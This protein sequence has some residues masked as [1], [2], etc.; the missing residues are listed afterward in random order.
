[1]FLEQKIQNLSEEYENNNLLQSAGSNT[2]L[3]ATLKLVES[4]VDTP[5]ACGG[6][7]H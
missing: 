1:M 7:I 3:L 6:A 2:P 5:S 4:F